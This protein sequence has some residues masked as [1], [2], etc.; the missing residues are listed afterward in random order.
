MCLFFS[1]L[2]G[3]HAYAT[4]GYFW[5]HSEPML[6][7]ATH[8]NADVG[9]IVDGKKIKLDTPTCEEARKTQVKVQVDGKY[10]HAVLLEGVEPFIENGR[11]LIPL[12]VIA[13]VFDFDVEW[14]QSEAKISL[15]KDEMNMIMH[16]GEE[17]MLV[18]DETVNIDGA[19]PLIRDN[20]TFL[21]V[22]QL[23]E[24]LGIQVEW[25]SETRTATFNQ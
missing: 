23:A 21:P 19:A 1:L 17:E 24:V 2:I 20:V 7:C 14:T 12:R 18:N 5:S 10:L 11:T 9:V 15:T 3:T 4:E 25:D 6:S 8:E 22:R 13:D 16:I